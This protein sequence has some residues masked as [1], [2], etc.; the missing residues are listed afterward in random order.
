MPVRPGKTGK[1]KTSSAAKKRFRQTASGKIVH[2]R[3]GHGHLLMQKSSRSKTEFGK[4]QVLAPG[5][6]SRISKIT[7]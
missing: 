5:D 7:L 1:Q 6:A 4:I 2:N 3:A